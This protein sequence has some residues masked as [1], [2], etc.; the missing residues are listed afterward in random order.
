MHYA[1]QIYGCQT[2]LRQRQRIP[3]DREVIHA[4]CNI[5]SAYGHHIAGMV[6]RAEQYTLPVAPI[7]RALLRTEDVQSC[8]RTHYYS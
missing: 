8:M 2:S 6:M 4:A 3:P 1:E 5:S 7:S